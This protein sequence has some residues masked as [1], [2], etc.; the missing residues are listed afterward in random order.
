MDKKTLRQ[1][2]KEKRQQLTEQE[3]E[4]K[5]LAIA[6]NLLCLDIWDKTYFHLFLPIVEQKEVDTEFILQILAGKDKEIMI[7]NNVFQIPIVDN[8]KR[9]IGLHLLHEMTTPTIYK[10][11]VVIVA[12]GKGLKNSK[13]F[14][15]LKDFSFKQ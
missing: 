10:N 6:N 4:E 11:R 9:L 5:S 2:Y 1:K 13:G 3:I 7:S 12:G 8:E 15:L 14:E